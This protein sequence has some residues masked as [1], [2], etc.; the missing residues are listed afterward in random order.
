MNSYKLG[1]G[2]LVAIALTLAYLYGKPDTPAAPSLSVPTVAHLDITNTA[3]RFPF[4]APPPLAETPERNSAPPVPDASSG[5][6]AL[7]AML[8]PL[9]SEINTTLLEI[10]SLQQLIYNPYDPYQQADEAIR[11]AYQPRVDDLSLHLEKLFAQA[12]DISIPHTL[13]AMWEQTLNLGLEDPASSQAL[14]LISISLDD[15]LFE[16]M[17]TVLA[18]G[19]YSGIARSNL[20]YSALLPPETRYYDGNVGATTTERATPRQQRIKDFLETQFLRES[21][22]EVLSTYLNI[23]HTMSQDAHGL[24]P[25]TQFAQQLEQLRSQISPDQYFGFRLQQQALTDPNTDVS[26]LLRDINSNPMTSQQRQSMMAMLSN[27]IF[28]E[29]SP[30][31][32]ETNANRVIP[33]QHQQLLLQYL[34]TGIAQPTLQDRYALSDYGTQRYAMELLK[35]RE[36]ADDTYYQRIID[37]KVL[38][39][40][41]GLILGSHMGGPPILEKLQNNTALRQRLTTQ[42]QQT[43]LSADARSALQDA[44]STI[45]PEPAILEP[46]YSPESMPDSV[47]PDAQS[48][49]Y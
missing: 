40:Q 13:R 30:N 3:A 17:L 27:S 14:S 24:V 21:D 2:L 19:E 23:Y 39:E 16:D 12:K 43:H 6:P 28:M 8:E 45:T 5:N 34:E 10:S 25:A 1:F 46:E 48:Q 42:L 15:T 47:Q 4:A 18:A 35:H 49:G 38:A 32:A 36:R 41:V 29:L 22:P 20:A 31:A 44:L 7:L 9:L 26:T 33:E 11:E 37:S